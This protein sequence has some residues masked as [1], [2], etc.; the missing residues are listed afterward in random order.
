MIVDQLRDAEKTQ[1]PV[2]IDRRRGLWQMES[3]YGFVVSMSERWVALQSF[4]DSVFFDGYEVVRI[5]DVVDVK[6]QR[7]EGYVERALAGLGRPEVDFT[8]AGA[9]TTSEVLKAA[10]DH[11]SLVCIRIEMER[12]DP[13][14]VGRIVRLGARKYDIHFIDPGG[15]WES[16]PRREWY[17]DVTR[18]M[19]GDRYSTT[20]ATA[21]AWSDLMRTL[22]PGRA[23]HAID[24]ASRVQE[25]GLS[26]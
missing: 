13:M 26:R 23:C 6:D 2:R 14:L 18:V 1:H 19:F 12:E 20:P 16:E 17:G 8:L 3:I 15:V 11:S 5:A 24:R 25:L 7:G 22:M 4:V 9:E 10:A 21:P